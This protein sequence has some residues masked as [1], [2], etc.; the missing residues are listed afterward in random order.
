LPIGD[1]LAPQSIKGELPELA[2]I[3]PTFNERD[4]IIPL[5]EKPRAVE[6][7][8]GIHLRG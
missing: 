6:A 8:L 3:V 1:E 4:N 2:I 5:L 7:V